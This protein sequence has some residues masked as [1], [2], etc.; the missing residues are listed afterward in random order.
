MAQHDPSYK[1]LFSHTRMVEDLIRGFVHEDWVA[2]LDF[3]TLERVSEK[4]VSVDLR[5][6]EDDMI[7]RLRWGERWL[8]VYLLLEFQSSVDRFMAV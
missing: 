2:E 7:W 8:Y 3:T 6:R 4:S 1:L 5:T